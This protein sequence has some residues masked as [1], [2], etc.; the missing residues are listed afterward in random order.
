MPNKLC[1]FP[2]RKPFRGFAK[3]SSWKIPLIVSSQNF[4]LL[5]S[6]DNVFRGRKKTMKSLLI[7]LQSQNKTK[8]KG[9]Q[10]LNHMKKKLEL[11]VVIWFCCF[12]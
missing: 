11:S 2:K 1:H 8:K 10:I 9:K 7:A 6:L 3:E 5:F 12:L 4:S